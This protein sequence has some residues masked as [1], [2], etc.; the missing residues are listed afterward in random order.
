MHPSAARELF[1]GLVLSYRGRTGL[2]QRDLAARA[3]V[4]ERS[5]QDWEAGI[6]LPTARRLQA[7]IGALL[8]AD[9]LTEGHETLEARGLWTAAERDARR[10][11]TPF[12]EEWFAGLL[13]ARAS[14]TRAEITDAAPTVPATEHRTGAANR[15]HDWGEA[16]DT[17]DFVGRAEELELLGRWV[18]EERC[19]LL[20]VLGFGGIGKTSLAARLARAS[21]RASSVCTGAV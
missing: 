15:A 17:L 8:E 18:L 9:G 19:R 12:D 13:A 2:I 6:S 4:S 11:Q 7:L 21:H 20:A 16:P 1:R 5:I 3:G 10:M 14:P